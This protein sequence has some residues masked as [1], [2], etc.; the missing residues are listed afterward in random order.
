MSRTVGGWLGGCPQLA[1]LDRCQCHHDGPATGGAH[2]ER[3]TVA[4]RHQRDTV[5]TILDAFD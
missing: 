4:S 5:P 1:F 2:R 3:T